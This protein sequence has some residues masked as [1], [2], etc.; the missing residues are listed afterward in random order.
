MAKAV[1]WILLFLAIEVQLCPEVEMCP[2]WRYGFGAVD[3]KERG[4]NDILP[5]CYELGKTGLKKQQQ[6]PAAGVRITKLPFE[7]PSRRGSFP[8]FT[9]LA[10][11]ILAWNTFCHFRISFY[12]RRRDLR[13]EDTFDEPLEQIQPDSPPP[14]HL[15]DIPPPYIADPPPP[16][17]EGPPPPYVDGPP[18]SYE[19]SQ[20][21]SNVGA[22]AFF[23]NPPS[24]NPRLAYVRYRLRRPVNG[25]NGPVMWLIL[26]RDA[27]GNVS[28]S[29]LESDS[30]S[31]VDH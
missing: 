6:K 13:D 2:A 24:Q 23:G 3:S 7:R 31:D 1:S 15:I 4:G 17:F 5:R 28:A 30:D 21:P 8:F 16:Y 12:R 29:Y 9:L 22:S 18:P 19:E 25:E 11:V 20:S 27:A 26:Q 14:H 10:S